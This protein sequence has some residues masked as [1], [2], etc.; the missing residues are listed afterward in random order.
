MGLWRHEEIIFTFTRV[1][2]ELARYAR[3]ACAVM[4]LLLV[5]REPL[6]L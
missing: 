6:L 2:F 5:R 1:L 4:G 3:L